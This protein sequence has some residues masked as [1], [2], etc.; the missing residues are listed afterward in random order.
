MLSNYHSRHQQQLRPLPSQ[1]EPNKYSQPSH[2]P[3][4]L[5]REWSLM[6]VVNQK[7]TRPQDKPIRLGQLTP[8][9]QQRIYAHYPELRKFA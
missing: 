1:S 3:Q 2:E 4:N 9:D 5:Q 6:N 7:G 8:E